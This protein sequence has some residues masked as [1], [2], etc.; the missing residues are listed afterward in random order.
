MRERVQ[1]EKRSRDDSDVMSF[2]A[3]DEVKI[4]MTESKVNKP[5]SL[6]LPQ[7][8]RKQNH[9]D[10]LFEKLPKCTINSQINFTPT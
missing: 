10:V 1:L 9:K 5:D 8:G 3:D 2:I 6:S 7:T 4:S